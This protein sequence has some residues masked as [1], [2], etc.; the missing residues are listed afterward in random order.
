MRWS[1]PTAF[2]VGVAVS[3]AAEPS[4]GARIVPAW[5]AVA[6]LLVVE[7]LAVCP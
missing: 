5:P 3:V 7:M 1:A 4:L 6:L 2:A